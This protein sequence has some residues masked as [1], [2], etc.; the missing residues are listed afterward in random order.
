MTLEERIITLQEENSRLR[1]QLAAATG[2][3]KPFVANA[4][5]FDYD[6]PGAIAYML[7]SDETE[8]LLG[9]PVIY[10]RDI[11]AAQAVLAATPPAGAEE[12]GR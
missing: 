2:A 11:R 9:T 4:H 7:M 12:D 1:D 3:L 5:F 8:R 6:K 10:V